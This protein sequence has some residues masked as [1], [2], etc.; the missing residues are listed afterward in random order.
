M[1]KLTKMI[2]PFYAL[3]VIVGVLFTIAAC[4]YGVMT[5]RELD[6]HAVGAAELHR[7]GGHPLMR[8]IDQHGLTIMVVQLALLAVA[9][10]SAMLTD[11][12]WTRQAERRS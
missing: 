6:P 10:L 1:N 2:N 8:F 4:A 7:E 11:E 5:I 12:Y 9:T 3:V